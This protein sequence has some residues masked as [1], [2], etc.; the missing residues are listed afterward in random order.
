MPRFSA[1]WRVDPDFKITGGLGL[2]AG[3][4][5]DVIT[6]TPFYNTGYATTSVDIQRTAPSAATPSSRASGAPGLH[7]GDRRGGR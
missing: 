3:G 4:T 6:G 1:E 7:P 2:F 5:P